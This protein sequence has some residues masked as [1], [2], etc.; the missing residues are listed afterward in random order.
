[1]V[2]KDEH[3]CMLDLK[4]NLKR[5]RSDTVCILT[6]I[7]LICIIYYHIEN[8]LILCSTVLCYNLNCSGDYA[9]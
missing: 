8:A 7:G 1:M 6:E 5:L 3:M 4:I 2:M 9:F